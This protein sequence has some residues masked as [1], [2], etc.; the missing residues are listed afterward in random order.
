MSE[1]VNFELIARHSYELDHELH[2]I[3][4]DPSGKTLHIPDDQ[5]D[6][7]QKR[8]TEFRKEVKEKKFKPM[9]HTT[10]DFKLG[11]V[12]ECMG[13]LKQSEQAAFATLL[14][15]LREKSKLAKKIAGMAFIV[16]DPGESNFII[17]YMD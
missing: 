10:D 16:R 4:M 2:F 11:F 12:Y 13:K 14:C 15:A 7:Y 6:F 8:I 1:E 3:L 9:Y 17:L 5:L